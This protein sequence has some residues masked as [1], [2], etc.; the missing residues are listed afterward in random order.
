MSRISITQAKI[1]SLI[2]AAGHNRPA[3][4]KQQK[5]IQKEVQLQFQKME[6]KIPNNPKIESI[7]TIITSIVLYNNKKDAKN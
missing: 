7:S 3:F 5:K 1:T 6:P 4:Q 2:K